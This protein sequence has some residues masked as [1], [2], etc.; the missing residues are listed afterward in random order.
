[1]AGTTLGAP[2]PIPSPQRTLQVAHTTRTRRNHV[3]FIVGEQLACVYSSRHAA[4]RYG[5][6]LELGAGTLIVTGA[7]TAAQ[8]RRIA[9]A[10]NA[11]A[12][13]SEHLIGGAR[14]G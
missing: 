4:P 9:A 2:S 12:D 3:A 1:M 10:L 7:M 6:C 11:A 14:H 13:A 5:V 8:A